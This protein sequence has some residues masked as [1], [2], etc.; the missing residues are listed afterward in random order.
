MIGAY[1]RQDIRR[2]FYWVSKL[3]H[4]RRS[5]ILQSLDTLSI[6]QIYFRA[7]DAAKAQKVF[8][9]LCDQ[10]IR[11]INFN[12]GGSSGRYLNSCQARCSLCPAAVAGPTSK[13]RLATLLDLVYW[14]L[15]ILLMKNFQTQNSIANHELNSVCV[16]PKVLVGIFHHLPFQHL[17]RHFSRELA[18]VCFERR[19][20]FPV[21]TTPL[22]V[23]PQYEGTLIN[24]LCM[25]NVGP[26]IMFRPLRHWSKGAPADIRLGWKIQLRCRWTLAKGK[27]TF[28]GESAKYH[29]WD[30]IEAKYGKVESCFFMFFLTPSAASA[31]LFDPVR[32]HDQNS[33]H[34]RHRQYRCCTFLYFFVFSV[35][36]WVD[37]STQ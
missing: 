18:R 36:Y 8:D 20:M 16:D 2:L 24:W 22:I 33:R 12:V 32:W 7:Q 19:R 37:L 5:M 25:D 30:G 3:S 27:G 29:L 28:S 4:A 15:L 14:C 31:S 21:W 11:Q 26:L 35:A 13:R 17:N 1:G 23:S 10:S 34:S 9:E 6:S